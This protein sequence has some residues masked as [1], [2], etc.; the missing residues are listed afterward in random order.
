MRHLLALT[1]MIL[2]SLLSPAASAQDLK[3][4][5]LTYDAD[6]V[7]MEG[8]FS[9]ADSDDDTVPLVLIVHQ[10]KGISDYEKR[11]A[12][13]I[14]AEGYHAFVVDMYGKGIRPQ[15]MEEAAA[16]SDKYKSDPTLALTRL[17][18]A[19]AYAKTLNG[20]DDTKIAIMGY[21]FGGTMALQLARSGADLKGAISFHGALSTPAPATAPGIVK[22]SLQIHHGADDPWVPKDEVDAF[23]AEMNAVKADWM[24]ISYA[25]AVHSF[26][27]KEAGDD[28]S[29]GAAYN[30]K[31]DRRSWDATLEFLD[32]VLD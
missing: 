29:K 9:R 21:C 23:I 26:T 2:G 15:T 19:L 31:A 20:V 3:G 8:Y 14:A 17:N 28:P 22:A 6:G 7:M 1:I 11:R 24:F 27:E 16:E 13:M 32:E 25:G 12:D 18:A 10:W 5:T 30:A 4:E